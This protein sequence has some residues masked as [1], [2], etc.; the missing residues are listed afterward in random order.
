MKAGDLPATKRW[1]RQVSWTRNGATHVSQPF[2]IEHSH[3]FVFLHYA[4]GK[5][6]QLRAEWEVTAR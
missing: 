2:A 4:T 3:G 1:N 6:H 5:A